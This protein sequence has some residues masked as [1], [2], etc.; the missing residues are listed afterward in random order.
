MIRHV[1]TPTAVSTSRLAGPVVANFANFFGAR[2]T[3]VSSFNNTGALQ[4]GR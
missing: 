3:H 1:I 2:I 4:A